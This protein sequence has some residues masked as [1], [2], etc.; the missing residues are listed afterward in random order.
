MTRR[1]FLIHA[2]RRGPGR[3]S[4]PFHARFRARSSQLTRIPLIIKPASL[5]LIRWLAISL[6]DVPSTFCLVLSILIF[7]CS[8]YYGY[9]HDSDASRSVKNIPAAIDR[10]ILKPLCLKHPPS[11]V[12]SYLSSAKLHSLLASK[13]ATGSVSAYN[14]L[15]RYLITW[16]HA[17]EGGSLAYVPRLV[18]DS[19][20]R[21]L[22]FI[23][24]IFGPE[25]SFGGSACV[26]YLSRHMGLCYQE[27]GTLSVTI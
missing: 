15:L 9:Y 25:R 2:P 11:V 22:V 18:H 12:P 5:S 16:L 8:T 10:V 6:H 20:L 13:P 4:S 7:E 23:P 21:T 14:Y 24:I 1:G 27:A 26:P 3:A 17:E 19:A